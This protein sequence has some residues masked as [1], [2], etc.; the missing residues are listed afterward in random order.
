[1][2][3]RLPRPSARSGPISSKPWP[4]QATVHVSVVNWRLG[5]AVSKAKLQLGKRLYLVDRIAAHL[6]L[7]ADL[8]EAVVL[9]GNRSNRTL[10]K[11]FMF[12]SAG[13]QMEG[14]AQMRGAAEGGVRSMAAVADLLTGRP[15]RCAVWPPDSVSEEEAQG[16]S[17]TA[18]AHVRERVCPKI[19]ERA[20]DPKLTSDWKNWFRRWWQPQ[21]PR[22]AFRKQLASKS[23][24]VVCARH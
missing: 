6:Q 10:S 5:E 17:P 15:F 24:L 9:Q 20:A 21:K 14:E 11:G 1:M 8:S 19:A 18:Y 12:G 2:A 16:R 23:R 7:Y 4:G 22:N 3:R 13:F